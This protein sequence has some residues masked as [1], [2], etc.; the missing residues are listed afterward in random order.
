M[1]MGRIMVIAGS[2]R[3]QMGRYVRARART[4]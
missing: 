2:S 4:N 1:I 3:P